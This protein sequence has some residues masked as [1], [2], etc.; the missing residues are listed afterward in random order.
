MSVDTVTVDRPA[1]V[2]YCHR[3]LSRSPQWAL[4]SQDLNIGLAFMRLLLLRGH[5]VG[6]PDISS[7]NIDYYSLLV[8]HCFNFY[9]CAR[10]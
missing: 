8:S 2:V 4:V 7:N 3:P 5:I 1:A 9:L 10:V 6:F